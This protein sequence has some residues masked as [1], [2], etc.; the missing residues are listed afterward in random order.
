MI[1]LNKS[2]VCV[3][4]TY[5]LEQFQILR[6]SAEESFQVQR[7][8]PKTRDADWTISMHQ[9]RKGETEAIKR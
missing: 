4:K 3:S 6:R 2:R 8:Q 9:K 7:Q 5:I 1:E